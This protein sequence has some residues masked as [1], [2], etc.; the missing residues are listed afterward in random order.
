[1]LSNEYISSLSTQESGNRSI[2]LT[3]EH[4]HSNFIERILWYRMR[5]R[6]GNTIDDSDVSTAIQFSQSWLHSSFP[7]YAVAFP[8][9]GMC[10]RSYVLLNTLGGGFTDLLLALLLDAVLDLH[11]VHGQAIVVEISRAVKHNSKRI[12]YG[13]GPDL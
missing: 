5:T 7:I 1:M 12:D 3:A 2:T 6:G 8:K 13:F 10:A 11:I 9:Q 4:T